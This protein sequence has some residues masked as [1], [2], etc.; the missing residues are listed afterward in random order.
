M[1]ISAFIVDSFCR[2]DHVEIAPDADRALLLISGKNAQGKTSLLGALTAAFGG[3]DALPEEP[4]RH[5]ANEAEILVELDDG[6]ITIRRTIKK[7]GE[8]SLEVRDPNGKMKKPQEVLDR[9]VGSR[10]LDP[11]AFLALPAAKQRAALLDL[12]DREGKIAK[13]D[14]R[15]VR[16]FDRRTEVG[17]DA[18]KAAAELERIPEVQVGTA[19]DVDALTVEARQFGEQQ[20]LGEHAH[21]KHELAK[22]NAINAQAKVEAARKRLE[23]LEAE[24]VEQYALIERLET[25]AAEGDAVE[26]S[27]KHAVDAGLEAWRV[28]AERRQQ[29]DAD[30]ARANAHNR[31]VFAAEAQAKRRLEVAA[32]VDRLAGGHVTL[33]TELEK[34]D[35]EKSAFLTAAKLPV[36]GLGVVA[37]GVTLRGVPLSQASGAEQLRVALALAIAASPQ[38]KDVWIRDGALLDDDALAELG[39]EAEALGIR[40]WVERVGDRDPGAIIIHDGRLKNEASHAA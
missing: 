24:I 17:R 10:F 1:R 16:V 27:S 38:L 21:S 13:L 31:A 22:S 26:V 25:A 36:D 6:A 7:T 19:I 35:A 12:I 4:V 37:D 30:L 8:S 39:R 32:E 23:A 34:I 20:R 33:T 9:I 15:R 28:T 3:K 14:E 29:V 18:K 5:G 2:I 40:C 11:L